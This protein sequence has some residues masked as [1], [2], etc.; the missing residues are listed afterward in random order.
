MQEKFLCH[1]DVANS[2]FDEEPRP[3]CNAGLRRHNYSKIGA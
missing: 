2:M 3:E 1:V